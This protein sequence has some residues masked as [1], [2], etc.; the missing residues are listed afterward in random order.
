MSPHNKGM[1]LVSNES[2]KVSDITRMLNN[3]PV[4][5]KPRFVYSGKKAEQEL[6]LSY[7]TAHVSFSDYAAASGG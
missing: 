5:E 3:Q 7:K 1:Q 2:W 6:G 4:V